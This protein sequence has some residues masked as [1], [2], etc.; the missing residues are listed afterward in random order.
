V[1]I[2][3]AGEVLIEGLQSRE[4]PVAQDPSAADT[5]E[6]ETNEPGDPDVGQKRLARQADPTT[7]TAAPRANPGGRFGRG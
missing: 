5:T 7:T 4:V 2:A 6:D 1:P 3:A